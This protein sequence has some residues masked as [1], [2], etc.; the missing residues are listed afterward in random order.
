V[1]LNFTLKSKAHPIPR[2]LATPQLVVALK[3][4]LKHPTYHGG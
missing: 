1:G 3:V 2:E 4:P